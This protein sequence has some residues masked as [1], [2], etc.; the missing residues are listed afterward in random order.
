ML[1]WICLCS[2]FALVAFGQASWVPHF[3]IGA[4]AFGF[5]IFWRA[6][7]MLP[8]RRDRFWLAFGWFAVI[9][10]IQISW[11]SSTQY[12]GPLILVIFVLLVVALGAQFGLLSFFFCEKELSLADCLA[13]AGCW[14]FLEWSRHY[15][16]S[17][18]AWN[19]VGLAMAD[20]SLSLQFASL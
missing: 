18:F 12:M 17:G 3:G 10:A 2:S 16:L 4:A 11:M 5:A 8:K 19:P 13:G 1:F 7:R 15:P 6:M 20:S 14:V 9:Q